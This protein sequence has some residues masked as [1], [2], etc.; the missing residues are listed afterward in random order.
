MSG[1]HDTSLEKE[2]WALDL[3]DVA[4]FKDQVK[5]KIKEDL[6]DSL[7]HLH[8]HKDEL[9]ELLK[10]LQLAE[11]QVT[12][13]ITASRKE[14]E[15][16]CSS[17]LQ[18]LTNVITRRQQ[19]LLAK[20][21]KVEEEALSPLHDCKSLLSESVQ[22]THVLLEQGHALCCS[23]AKGAA[24]AKNPVITKDSVYKFQKQAALRNCL[25]S[26]P[27]PHAV[28][29]VS[30]EFAAATPSVVTT[31]LQQYGR[32]RWVGP[33]QITT[34]LERPGSLMVHWQEVSSE[35]EDDDDEEREF[36][37]QCSGANEDLAF[38]QYRTVYT[39]PE[40]CFLLQQ[41]C[42]GAKYWLR[43][44]HVLD[45]R[46][47]ETCLICGSEAVFPPVSSECTDADGSASGTWS[48]PR[49]CSTNLP[50]Y[51][52][53]DT[54]GWRVADE[55]RL[56]TKTCSEASVICTA[57]AQVAIDCSLSLLMVSGSD[58]CCDDGVALSWRPPTAPDLLSAPGCLFLS[59]T[60]SVIVDGEPR[61]MKLPCLS[62][63]S[64]VSVNV[65]HTA[66][67]SKLRVHMETAGKRV[68]YD[69]PVPA[70]FSTDPRLYFCACFAGPSWTV[71]VY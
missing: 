62:P 31:L 66:S 3:N 22:S 20:L 29:S 2:M 28:A 18:L 44:A 69:W 56:A 8:M 60:G 61:L 68:T 63:G 52:W 19:D 42:T 27:E 37:L 39:G 38:A 36:V 64:V 9:G 45:R 4:S 35:D 23:T 16:S 71:R 30:V 43:V 26:V 53:S 34:V 65:E 70:E 41:V 32:V 50:H 54:E 40:S 67:S 58:G 1:S 17:L 6:E 51:R 5:A 12:E 24:D 47:E 14:V 59:A 15:D 55:G 10:K 13:S 21:D 49:Q 11:D 33:V 57:E 48:L 25:P 7:S 46:E